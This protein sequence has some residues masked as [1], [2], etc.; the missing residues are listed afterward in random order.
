ML[1]MNEQGLILQKFLCLNI[2][3]SFKRRTF[4]SFSSVVINIKDEGHI[5]RPSGTFKIIHTG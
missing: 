4:D 5:I 1:Q 2:P 3:Q